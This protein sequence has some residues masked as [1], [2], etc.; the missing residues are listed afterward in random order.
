MLWLNHKRKKKLDLDLD[1][2]LVEIVHGKKLF[3][4][5]KNNVVFFPRQIENDIWFET[6]CLGL[7]FEV[8]LNRQQNKSGCI[9]I[10]RRKR[11]LYVDL[12]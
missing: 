10:H 1:L 3:S 8:G 2:D 12:A 11:L 9:I 4:K 7:I 5:E 6:N